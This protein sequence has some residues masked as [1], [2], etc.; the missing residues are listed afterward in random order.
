MV[1][2]IKTQEGMPQSDVVLDQFH[3][4]IGFEIN[5]VETAFVKKNISAFSKK[6][7]FVQILSGEDENGEPI[8]DYGHAFFYLT[9][10]QIVETF[11]SF[12]PSGE[13]KIKMKPGNTEQPKFYADGAAN[14]RPSTGSYAIT[15]VVRIFRFEITEDEFNK[16]IA[17]T[18][19]VL[20][21][22]E[23]GKPY[24]AITNDTCAEEA[25]DILDNV[26]NWLPDGK[27]YIEN[28]GTIFPFKMVSP[29]AWAK[30]FYDQYK[31]AYTYPE[32]PIKGK[33]NSILKSEGEYPYS[34]EEWFLSKGNKDPLSKEGY[35]SEANKEQDQSSLSNRDAELVG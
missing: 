11:F 15:E 9:K 13:G 27:G 5:Q 8:G 4:L 22:I 21:K 30:Q 7:D 31:M 35:Y 25:Q 14:S 18:N 12:G 28:N 32:Y 26:L 2:K 33:G 23:N 1:I 10:N 24:R 20:M 19:K 3:L 29:Y 34:V 16:I 6:I 17:G